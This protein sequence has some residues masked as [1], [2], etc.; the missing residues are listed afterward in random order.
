[1]KIVSLDNEKGKLQVTSVGESPVNGLKGEQTFD[2][3]PSVRVWR[4]R[5]IARMADLAPEQ[6][7]QLN[8]T[9]AADWKNGQMSV[10]DVWIDQESRDVAAEMQRQIHIRH[11]RTRWLAGWVDHVE[12]QPGG[13]GIVTVTLFGGM[14]PSLYEAAKASAKPGGSVAL[15]AAEPT[16]RGWWQ[17]HDNKSGPV[18]DFKEIPNPPAAAVCNSEFKSTSC[19]KGFARRE[20]CASG[21]ADL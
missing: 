14:D 7:V 13:K 19:S 20:L 11:Q 21:P 5:E 18:V 9:W 2:I 8:F 1:M 16:L 4:G 12:H 10:A 3:D 6:I 15:A 17:D